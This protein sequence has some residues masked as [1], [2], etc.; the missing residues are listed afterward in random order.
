MSICVNSLVYLF[1]LKYSDDTFVCAIDGF[2]AAWGIDAKDLA[3]ISKEYGTN[4][5]KH[6]K[7]FL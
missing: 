6:L 2:K 1:L 3:K 4:T 5:Q 7:N